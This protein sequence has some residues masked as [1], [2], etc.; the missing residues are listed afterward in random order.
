MPRI[1]LKNEEMNHTVFP[2]GKAILLV[3]RDSDA[4]IQLDNNDISRN[5]ASI[6]FENGHYIVHDNGSTNGTFVNGKKVSKQ[7]LFH[8]DEIRFGPYFFLVD[9]SETNPFPDT[10]NEQFVD[11]DRSGREYRSSSNLLPV[12]GMESAGT[13]KVM[14][15]RP[16][17]AARI[18][19]L[20]PQK[21]NPFPVFLL[22]AVGVSAVIAWY[23]QVD[24]NETMSKRYKVELAELKSSSETQIE[25]LK[26]ET[27]QVREALRISKEEIEKALAQISILKARNT[28]EASPEN[29]ALDNPEK[30]Q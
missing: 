7:V 6:I 23:L 20:P 8:N 28:T 12:K 29:G 21:K 27:T 13:V 25:A 24:E 9:L 18:P 17:A 30:P 16:S 19:M 11:L 26:A 1:I 10:M 15:S 2:L 22:A 5:H 3:G 4:E 14:M